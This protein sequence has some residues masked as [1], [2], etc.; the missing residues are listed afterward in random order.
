MAHPNLSGAFRGRCPQEVI[1][2]ILDKTDKETLK[3][4]A[5]VARAFQP[6]SQK[7][8]FADLTI[9]PPGHDSI[10]VLQ[11]LADVLSASSRRLAKH[12]RTLHLFQYGLY[13]PCVWM[14]S[15]I[16]PVILSMLTELKSLN[17]RIYNWDY[18]HMNCEQAV[19]ALITRSSLSSIGLKEARLHTNPTLLSLLRSLPTSLKS[20]SFLNVFA[21]NWS[22]RRGEDLDKAFPELHQL[23]LASLHLDSLAPA[24]FDW[25]N[26]VVDLECI[27]HLHTTVGIDTMEVLQQ[28]LNS[29]VY[30]E[31]YHLSLRS[32]FCAC[33]HDASAKLTWALAT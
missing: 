30:V 16:L 22:Y 4:C 6:T 5:L 8:L 2:L 7:L 27:R 11:R 32:T 20:V 15:D 28:L 24:L 31:T 9:L 19:Y 26:R 3:S 1:D 17:V 10:P 33:F 21:N 14:Q 12:V 23:H 18:F 29:A 25:A 13:E